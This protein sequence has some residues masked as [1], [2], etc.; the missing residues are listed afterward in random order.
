MTEARTGTSRRTGADARFRRFLSEDWRRWMVQVPE[1]ATGV[2][3]PGQN[4]RWT[5]DSPKGIA[6]RER[7][8]QESLRTYA[9]FAPRS[10]SPTERLNHRL[11]GGLLRTAAA[12]RRFGDDP[13]PFHFG[14]PRNLWMPLNQMDGLHIQAGQLLPI[15]P[16]RTRADVEAIVDRLRGLPLAVTQTIALL[17]E[18]RR[19]GVVPPRVALGGVAAQVDALVPEK[20]DA[21]ALWEPMRDLPSSL[22]EADR[23]RLTSDARRLYEEQVRPAF[24]RLRQHLVDVYLPATRATIGASALP[25]GPDGYAHH[26]RWT[27]TTDQTPQQIHEIGLA[28][29][30]RTRAE[31]EALV[32]STGFTGT[33]AEFHRFLRS[34]PRFRFGSAEE[35]VDDYRA[36]AK[37]IDPELAVHFGRLPRLP[38]GVRP[39]PEFQAP[40]VPAA[41][42][43][44]GSPEEGRPGN[45]YVNTYDLPARLRW[46]MESLTLHEAVPG[47]HLQLA[48]A[49]ELEDVPEFR[50]FSG[51]TAFVEGWGL[52]AETLGEELGL[53]RDPY[54]RFGALDHDIWRSI[55]L[56][57]DTGMHAL[58]WSR[59]RAIDFFREHTGMTEPEI[60]VEVDRYI[61]WPGQALAYKLGQ[62]KLRELRTL[63]ETS[64]G[65]AFDERAFH[66]TVL[67]D[68]GLPLGE[69]EA[70]V[71]AWIDRTRASRPR[72]M[73][74]RAPRRR[75]SARRA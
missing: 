49:A 61:V 11:Y 40:S 15:Q 14:Y 8:L 71:R 28:E 34:D 47:H 30:R 54:A 56:V 37:R 22:T 58:G 12:G 52:Y 57:V 70:R 64:L 75:S 5:D 39:I 2:G 45:F 24:Q 26:V 18:G 62:L 44:S 17:E 36:L 65:P 38:Y 43:V 10:L 69:L 59:E 27:T 19:R 13:F 55:R 48:L 72:R 20:I 41:Y 29:V 53:Y 9:R 60:T 74:A 31:I 35:L 33:L 23:S 63:A 50:R 67:A 51:E 46:R 6:A 21:S 7:H 68:G 66:D 3:Y 4:G 42:Y 25:D 32:R 16:R 73:A 1:V